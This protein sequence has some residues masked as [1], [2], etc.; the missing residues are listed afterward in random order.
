MAGA[1]C[2]GITL[3]IVSSLRYQKGPDVAVIGLAETI[4]TFPGLLLVLLLGSMGFN[5]VGALI[6]V[7]WMMPWRVLR[8]QLYQ[9]RRR[10]YFLSA[11]SLGRS[12]SGAMFVHALPNVLLRN[13]SLLLTMIADMLAAESALEFLGLGPPLDQPSLGRQVFWAL[14]FSFDYAWTWVPAV[15]LIVSFVGVFQWLSSRLSK[16][17]NELGRNK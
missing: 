8:V 11:I 5:T 12:P 7:Y 17:E 6:A 4:R 16:N 10:G 3:A 1:L 9:E 2:I 15:V 13:R 14:D